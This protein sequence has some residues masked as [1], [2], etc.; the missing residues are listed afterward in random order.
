VAKSS[1]LLPAHSESTFIPTILV[2]QTVSSPS[3]KESKAKV[4]IATSNSLTDILAL[5][6]NT[7]TGT[8]LAWTLV[9]I[10]SLTRPLLAI[11]LTACHHVLQDNTIT[12][13][14]PAKTPVIL[15]YLKELLVVSN[16]VIIFVMTMNSSNSIVFVLL[17]VLSRTKPES[18]PTRAIAT[19]H[20]PHLII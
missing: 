17:N 14:T 20:V 4:I 9:I 10:P 6:A 16:I 2:L 15:L 5:L 1:A 19:L 12:G 7:T 18:K 3:L 11:V 13:M 8:L